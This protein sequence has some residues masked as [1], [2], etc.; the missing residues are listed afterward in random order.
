MTFEDIKECFVSAKK[1]DAKGR[2]HKGLLIAEPNQWLAEHYITKAREN[3]EDCDYYRKKRRD[4]KLPEAWFYTLYY[5]ALA[6]LSKFGVETRSQKCT[7]VFL[8]Y[9]RDK[10]LIKYD[11]DFIER[12]T[13]YPEKE[14]MTDVDKREEARYGPSIQIKEVQD[15]YAEMMDICKKAIEQCRDI[16]YSDK[17]LNI[18]KEL[19]GAIKL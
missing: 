2:K 3:L 17:P 18:P 15:K 13:V 10:E 12:I 6:I 19:L 4:Y 16:V 9:V 14:H 11:D 5:C 8:R 1:T 7:A